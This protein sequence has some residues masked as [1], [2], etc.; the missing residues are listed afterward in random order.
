MCKFRITFIFLV[1]AVSTISCGPRFSSQQRL[2]LQS[3]SEGTVIDELV[4]ELEP[5]E[6]TEA[7]E[8]YIKSLRTELLARNPEYKGHTNTKI[9]LLARQAELKQEQQEKEERQKLERERKLSELQSEAKQAFLR[10][11]S[12]VTWEKLYPNIKRDEFETE[13]AFQKRIPFFDFDAT[14]YFNAPTEY[15]SY[16]ISKRRIKIKIVGDNLCSTTGMYRECSSKAIGIPMGKPKT[17][18]SKYKAVNAFGAETRVIKKAGVEYYLLLTNSW[19]PVSKEGTSVEMKRGFLDA[20]I[21]IEMPMSPAD[22]KRIKAKNSNIFV[23]V[24]ARF[25]GRGDGCSIG[26]FDQRKPTRTIPLEHNIIKMG[27]KGTLE[28]IIIFEKR[29]QKIKDIIVNAAQR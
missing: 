14:Y 20:E 2:V 8:E 9:S 26:T 11:N 16:D 29:G 10:R 15:V 13:E 5:T 18:L 7:N 12:H 6:K 28:N 19:E 17:K 21:L 24:G 4:N 27:A 25:C 23:A 3:F 1:A 22:A